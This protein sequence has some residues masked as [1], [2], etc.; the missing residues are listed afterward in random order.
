MAVP[1][2]LVPVLEEAAQT[3]FDDPDV[4]RR[5]WLDAD[6]AWSA[7]GSSVRRHTGGTT[8]AVSLTSRQT[9]VLAGGLFRLDHDPAVVRALD[10]MTGRTLERTTT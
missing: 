7:L 1:T 3:V 2:D 9:A 4:A 6:R 8:V 10:L 5:T